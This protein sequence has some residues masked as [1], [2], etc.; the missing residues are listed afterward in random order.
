MFY[1][2]NQQQGIGQKNRTWL[3]N[4]GSLTFSIILPTHE[5]LSL[6]PLELALLCRNFFYDQ[7]KIELKVK[8][9]NDLV[10]SQN[11]KYG[12]ILCH[13]R[14]N[15]VVAGIGLN[16]FS[17]ADKS[18]DD[19]QI[20]YV[21]EKK[22]LDNYELLLQLVKYLVSNRYNNSAQIHQDWLKHCSHMNK[23]VRLDDEAQSVTGTFLGIGTFGE[24]LVKDQAGKLHH[25]T[26]GSFTIY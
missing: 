18:L 16:L 13:S 19:Y 7:Y 8:W 1:S 11:K 9:P 15:Q 23:I 20:G 3:S 26:N 25:I 5:M 17:T 12:G 24:A 22:I 14:R 21:F 6:T 4:F 10:D 2:P